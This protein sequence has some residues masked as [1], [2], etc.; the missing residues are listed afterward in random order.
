MAVDSGDPNKLYI[1]TYL[2]GA[3]L[4]T[5]TDGGKTLT[6]QAYDGAEGAWAVTAGRADEVWISTPNGL[7][8]STDAGQTAAKVLDGN[9]KNVAVHGTEVV[10][11]GQNLVKISTDGGKTFA[12][13][14]S[15]PA[16]EYDAVTLGPDGSLYVGSRTSLLR[17]DGKRWTPLTGLPDRDVRSLLTT[18]DWLFVGTGS[19]GVYRLPL[20]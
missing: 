3:S 2:T 16:A 5:S 4:Y 17:G 15:T 11:V 6:P 9:V 19:S 13:A 12:D 18:R 14:P 10:A 8:H 7:F 1:A 20:R